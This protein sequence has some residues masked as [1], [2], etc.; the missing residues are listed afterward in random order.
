VQRLEEAREKYDQAVA[1]KVNN[2]F[3]HGNRYGVAFL[4]N[5]SSGMEQQIAA[6]AGKPGEDVLL[7]FASD[8]EAYHGR[9]AASRDLSKRAADSALRNDS[10]ETAAAWQMDVALRD[11]EFDNVALSRQETASALAIASTRDVS[12]LAALVLARIGDTAKAKRM[13]DDLAARFPLNTVINRYWLPTIYASI[14]IHR[15]NPAGAVELLKTTSEYELASPL[16]QFEVGGSLYPVYVRGEAYLLL[17]QGKEAAQEFQKYLDH[18]GVAV[19][20]PLEALARLQ[21][22]RADMLT[23][24]L[25]NA[26]EK[27]RQFFV[28][29]KSSDPDIPILKRAQT[30]YAKLH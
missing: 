14:A 26:K 8:T 19:N 1:H 18:S 23:G 9:L 5:D 3:L 10:P 21:L 28:L 22:A 13:A 12:I 20:C 6:A 15:G 7:S 30:E 4:E 25:K 16:P 27:Y 11:A 17:H 29:W 24:D 2:P